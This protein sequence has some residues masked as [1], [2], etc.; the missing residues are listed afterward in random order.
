MFK[1]NF[2]IFI[3]L[4]SSTIAQNTSEPIFFVGPMVH[5]N[6]GGGDKKFSFALEASGWLINKDL[7]LPL[8]GDLGVEF[9][10]KKVRVYSE[11]QTGSLLGLSLGPVLEFSENDPVLGFQSSIWSAFFLGFDMRYRRINKMNYYSP[12]IFFKFP[13]LMDNLS[14]GF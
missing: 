12:G 13:F 2:L 8:G 4:T 11:L 5:Y 7:P 3:L 6:I 1:F 10:R 14:T 9:Q